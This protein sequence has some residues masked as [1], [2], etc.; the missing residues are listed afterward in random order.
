MKA[1]LKDTNKFKDILWSWIGRINIVEVSSMQ[2]MDS[3]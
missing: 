1:I 2:P 3:M